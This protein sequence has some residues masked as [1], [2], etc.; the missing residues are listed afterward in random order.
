[1]YG[2]TNTGNF[3]MQNAN[4]VGAQLSRI[5]PEEP[6]FVQ[7]QDATLVGNDIWISAEM[8]VDDVRVA[9]L[10]HYEPTK[11]VITVEKTLNLP[12]P[13]IFQTSLQA[14]GNRAIML[15][16]LKD[17]Y[18]YMISYDRI[19]H[20]FSDQL[21]TGKPRFQ[22][23]NTLNDGTII[24]KAGKFAGLFYV[25]EN[26]YD[27]GR[28][29]YIGYIMSFV[30]PRI[31]LDCDPYTLEISEEIKETNEEDQEIIHQNNC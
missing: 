29:E 1:M 28:N 11:G 3:F 26:V 12:E 24:V 23:I 18:S 4:S 25:D 8:I 17:L 10:V 15:V 22:I 5:E 13:Q 16:E 21:I 6:E 19:V 7:V 30:T 20:S 2:Q 31:Q 27:A 14:F 9:A